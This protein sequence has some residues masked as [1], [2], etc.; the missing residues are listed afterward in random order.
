MMMMKTTI[1]YKEW[2]KK[3]YASKKS[4]QEKVLNATTAEQVYNRGKYQI[5]NTRSQFRFIL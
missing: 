4:L 1:I 2:K 5:M 3:M